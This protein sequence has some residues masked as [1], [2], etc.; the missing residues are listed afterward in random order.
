MS[1]LCDRPRPVSEHGDAVAMRARRVAI[2]LELDDRQITLAA[3]AGAV[4]DIGKVAIPEAVIRK[5][6]TL[7]DDEYNLVKSHSIIGERICRAVDLAEMALYVRHHHERFDGGG[8]PDGLAGEDVPL[9]SRIIFVCD[10]FDAIT[11]DRAYRKG[12]PADEAI[13]EIQRNAGTQFDPKCVAALSV[14]Y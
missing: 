11:S 3:I 6:G 9:I 12:R 1:A 4:H 8:Y 5:P 14:V 13:S 7:T 10:T 2:E